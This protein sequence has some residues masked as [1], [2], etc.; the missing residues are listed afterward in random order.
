MIPRGHANNVIDVRV[1]ALHQPA[2]GP[3]SAQNHHTGLL[4]GLGGAQAHMRGKV[5]GVGV[6]S[7]GSGEV[8]EEGGER[9]MET[10]SYCCV[11]CV[12]F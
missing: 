3:T 8:R 5:V 2:T 6:S 12:G 1:K 9:C 4:V 10:V 7:G 11:K